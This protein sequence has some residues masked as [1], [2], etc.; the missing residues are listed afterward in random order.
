MSNHDDVE[1]LIYD[2]PKGG[3]NEWRS[4]QG[5]SEE[6]RKP[7]VWFAEF[8]NSI[9]TGWL[10]TL[11]VFDEPEVAWFTAPL[12]EEREGEPIR[13]YDDA[14][15]EA[16]QYLLRHPHLYSDKRG[17][18]TGVSDAQL[19]ALP[20]EIEPGEFVLTFI[21]DVYGERTPM[22]IHFTWDET[23]TAT[24]W[25]DIWEGAPGLSPGSSAPAHGWASWLNGQ[26]VLI[27]FTW[28]DVGVDGWAHIEGG[29]PGGDEQ[30]D[31]ALFETET[32]IEF[33]KRSWQPSTA[34]HCLA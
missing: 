31:Y 16:R 14:V 30:D 11:P 32:W 22:E 26:D 12:S 24:W 15:A 17:G 27:A 29:A 23:S 10:L 2:G 8:E 28:R 18:I 1:V 34:P 6:D 7:Y 4:S 9:T 25:C 5:W 20:D 19:S 3:V 21:Q 33:G 13:T